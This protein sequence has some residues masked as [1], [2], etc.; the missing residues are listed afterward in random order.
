MTARLCIWDC[1]ARRLSAIRQGCL[2]PMSQ[3]L[4]SSRS[5][6]IASM[7]LKSFVAARHVA[8]RLAV[9]VRPVVNTLSY[10]VAPCHH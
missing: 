5:Y 6:S 8:G 2:Y 3:G 9:S 10:G 7:S 4:G 1:V